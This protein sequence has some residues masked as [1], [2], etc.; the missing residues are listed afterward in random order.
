MHNIYLDN[1]S[2]TAMEAKVADAM[3]EV[4]GRPINASSAHKMGRVARSIV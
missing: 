3:I 4:L 1:N 2:T